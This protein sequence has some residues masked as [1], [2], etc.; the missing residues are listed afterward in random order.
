M[1]NKTL[2]LFLIV[3]MFISGSA[4]AQNQR[5]QKK[6]MARMERQRTDRNLTPRAE[7]GN[8]FT[9]EQKKTLKEKRLEMAKQIKPLRNELGELE[10]RQRTL[11]TQDKPDMKAIYKNIEKISDVK[12]EIAKILAKHNQDVREMLTEE[13]LQRFDAVKKHRPDYHYDFNR[14]DRMNRQR[15]EKS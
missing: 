3:A 6:D 4:V 5:N 15:F 1:K 14:R 13:Q 10:A 12:T 9:D 8:F 7:R 11:S 2:G